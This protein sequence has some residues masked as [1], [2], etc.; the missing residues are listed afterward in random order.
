MFRGLVFS[1][2]GTRY[3]NLEWCCNNGC[4]SHLHIVHDHSLQNLD[5]T[6]LTLKRTVLLC[7]SVCP[8]QE[9]DLILHYVA[10]NSKRRLMPR[11]MLS[12][13][14]VSNI[15]ETATSSFS[16]VRS[17]LSP[18]LRVQLRSRHSRCGARPFHLGAQRSWHL[19]CRP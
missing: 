13:N 6:H 12:L 7:D 4:I 1:S 16:S 10:K 15:I 14:W 2:A 19:A 8:F 9:G 5:I 11:P 18:S 3:T 17:R